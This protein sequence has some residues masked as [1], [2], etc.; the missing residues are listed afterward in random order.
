[1]H[2]GKLNEGMERGKWYVTAR[3]FTC[4]GT[5]DTEYLGGRKISKFLIWYDWDAVIDM[6]WDDW[7]AVIVKG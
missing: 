1:M 4:I 7:D 6:T 5:K 2:L 3:A